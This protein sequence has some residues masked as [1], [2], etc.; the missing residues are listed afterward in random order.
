MNWFSCIDL[1]TET[2]QGLPIIC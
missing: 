2:V 1:Q